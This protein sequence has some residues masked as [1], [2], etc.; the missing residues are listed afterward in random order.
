MKKILISP[1]SRRLSTGPNAK[2]YPWWK[3]VTRN[4]KEKGFYVIQIGDGADED[5][6]ANEL[7]LNKRFSE[8]KKMI[9]ECS[10]WA[11]VDNFFHHFCAVERKRGVAIFGISD[12]IIFGHTL[13]INLLKD[14]S[15]LRPDQ[16]NIWS[17]VAHNPEVFVSPELVTQAILSII[18]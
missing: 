13:N 18:K 14:R 3:D 5:I 6:G 9:A 12:P 17:G 11:S 15:Y 4:L 8:L 10:T 2:N 1:C 16:Y 7:A